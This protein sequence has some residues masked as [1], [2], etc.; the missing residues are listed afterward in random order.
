MQNLLEYLQQNA[1]ISEADFQAITELVEVFHYPKKQILTHKGEVENYIYYIHAGLVRKFFYKK[2]KEEAITHI[3]RENDLISSSVSFFSREVSE[4]VVETLEPCTL[5]AMS[6]GNLQKLFSLG[7]HMDKIGK[8]LTLDFLLQMEIWERDRLIL[9]PRTRFVK[10]INE[11][12]ELVQRV[13]QRHLAS[14]LNMKPE[15]F[16]RYKHLLRTPKTA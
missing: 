1:D 2:N 9:E 4:Y 15:T 11:N 13:Q 14:Y 5:Y 12:P 8:Q 6:Y 10:F 16:S 3:A 7:Y